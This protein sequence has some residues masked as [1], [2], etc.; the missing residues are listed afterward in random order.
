MS[1]GSDAAGGTSAFPT[2]PVPSASGTNVADNGEGALPSGNDVPWTVSLVDGV[3]TAGRPKLNTKL[4]DDC[5]FSLVINLHG[6]HN[7]ESI[8]T[9]S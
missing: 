9:A 4:S 6:V 7:L 5:S 8:E 2:G 1:V 3:G